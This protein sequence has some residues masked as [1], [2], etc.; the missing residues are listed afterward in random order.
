M[1]V[2]TRILTPTGQS[3]TKFIN[4]VRSPLYCFSVFES[5]MSEHNGNNAFLSNN[6]TRSSTALKMHLYHFCGQNTR[7]RQRLHSEHMSTIDW[8]IL[9]KSA[10]T[11][12]IIPYVLLMVSVRRDWYK[13]R[14]SVGSHRNPH[15]VILQ[16]SH[17]ADITAVVHLEYYR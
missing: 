8:Y 2:V 15:I 13:T 6:Y 7:V 3:W 9:H 12:F 14:I 1:H 4:D 5:T 11:V 17:F 16:W 10:E